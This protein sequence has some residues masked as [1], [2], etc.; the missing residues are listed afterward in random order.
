MTPAETDEVTQV[1][2]LVSKALS[3]DLREM[4]QARHRSVAAEIRIAIAAHV[5]RWQSSGAGDVAA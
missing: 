2:A 3:D 5:E 4:A 1:A